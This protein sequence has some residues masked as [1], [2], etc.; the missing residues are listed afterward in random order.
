MISVGT[1]HRG[2]KH[3]VKGAFVRR[4][5]LQL[6]NLDKESLSG[7]LLHSLLHNLTIFGTKF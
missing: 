4:K 7:N 6:Q 2:V 3:G 5:L 1:P